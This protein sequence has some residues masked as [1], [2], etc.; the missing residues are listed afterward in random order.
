MERGNLVKAVSKL[1]TEVQKLSEAVLD[2]AKKVGEYFE[3][4]KS[5]HEDLKKAYGE[6]L[7]YVL[8]EVKAVLARI[9][10]QPKVE[11]RLIADESTDYKTMRERIIRKGLSEPSILVN[12]ILERSISPHEVVTA[13]RL[14]SERERRGRR[15]SR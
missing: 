4:Q 3:V 12:K 1:E 5:L 8:S 15:V 7:K 9:Q 6:D 11:R 13:L 10:T 2:L 14:I